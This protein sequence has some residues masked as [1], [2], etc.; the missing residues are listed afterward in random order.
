LEK[1]PSSD[2]DKPEEPSEEEEGCISDDSDEEARAER[3]KK[4]RAEVSIR[5]REK[6]VQ[7]SLASHLRDRD[8]E[9][10]FHRHEEAIQEFQALMTDL[11][12][13]TDTSWKDIKKTLKEDRRWESVSIL[14]REEME[15]LYNSHLDSIGKKK[16]QRFRQANHTTN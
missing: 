1:E 12:R 2:N 6:E 7:K 8:K 4:E 10:D 14:S 11:V 13:N 16:R 5:E 9:R 15:D 3:E